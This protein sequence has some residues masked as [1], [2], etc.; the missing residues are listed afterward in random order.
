MPTP[1]DRETALE[2]R[3]T[4]LESHLAHLEA[5]NQDLS[6]VI[7]RQWEEIDKLVRTVRGLH[8]R[9]QAVEPQAEAYKPPH[10]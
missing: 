7:A 3:V 1:S 5:A 4:A 9:M 2:Q 10:Y 6:D 8:D